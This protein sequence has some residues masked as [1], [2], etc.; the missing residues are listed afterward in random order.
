SPELRLQV[1]DRLT[2]Q[3]IHAF[4]ARA[5]LVTKEMG[6]QGYRMVQMHINENGLS[7]RPYS[8]Q[9]MALRA[10]AAPAMEAGTQRL[11]VQI[12]GTIELQVK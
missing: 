7:P 4:K 10:E 11:E 2:A 8:M 12:N 5:D 1:Q 9:G 6:R 3:A